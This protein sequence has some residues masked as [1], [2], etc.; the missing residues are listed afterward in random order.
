M[1]VRH[2]HTAARLADVGP[3]IAV[4]GPFTARF[5][6]SFDLAV[7]LFAPAVE[8]AATLPTRTELP[9]SRIGAAFAEKLRREFDGDAE[10]TR[11]HP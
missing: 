6:S 1:V 10:P 2:C 3:G 4:V 7:R 8:I 5:V 9:L 11:A